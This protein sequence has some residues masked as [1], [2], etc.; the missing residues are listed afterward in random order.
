M[1]PKRYRVFSREF[2]EAAVRRVLAGEKVRVVATDLQIVPKLLYHWWHQYEAGG[3]ERLRPAGRPPAR[4]RLPPA[5]AAARIAELER[6]VGQQALELD[7][8]ARALRHIEASVPP[9]GGRGAAASS[10]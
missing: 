1:P 8:F 7:F 2:K 5:D 9:N 3:V 6:K 4:E 10:P